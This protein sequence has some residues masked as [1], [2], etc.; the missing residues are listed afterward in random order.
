MLYR[1]LCV[2]FVAMFASV[3]VVSA[4]T[5][6]SD[7]VVVNKRLTTLEAI[8]NKLPKIGG[9][10]NARYQYSSESG[11]Y[12]SGKN[13]FDIRR[14]QINMQGNVLKNLT[15]YFQLECAGSPRI[16]DA[17][18][19][20]SLNKYLEI[21][22]GQYKV[23]YTLEN[24][25]AVI[26]LE[27]VENSQAIKA[28]VTEFEGVKCSGRDMG[29][30]VNGNLLQR[31]G[32]NIVEYSLNL[33]N[34]NQYN[35]DNNTN[36]DFVGTLCVNP[37]KPLRFA[38]SY[39]NGEY[40]PQPSKIK[41]TLTSV[42]VKFDDRK[43]QV[44]S[45]YISALTDVTRSAGFYLTTAYYLTAKLQPVLKYD[46]YTSD[47]S[48]SLSQVTALSA[49]LNYW[50]TSNSKVQCFYTLKSFNDR[51]KRDVNTFAAQYLLGF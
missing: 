1:F 42:G 4:Q 36:K 44:R 2:F 29:I 10:V 13:G 35:V 12:N 46:S 26:D 41:R 18:A 33:L 19:R 17:Y 37:V 11:N 6:K 32:F 43:L 14:L 47:K 3:F 38:L 45:E 28:L 48:N 23:M 15:Y 30:A 21:K 22:A 40:G 24:P 49:G 7:S 9:V 31:N 34:G 25:Y 16:L 5:D 8:V 20:W 39:Y 50:L 51:S 27:T